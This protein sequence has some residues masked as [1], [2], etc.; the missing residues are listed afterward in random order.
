MELWPRLLY[1]RPCYS[2]GAC[3]ESTPPM[4]LKIALIGMP[5]IGKT[6]L[7]RKLASSYALGFVDLDQVIE[8]AI[9]C[10]IS[11]YFERM[12]EAAF[13]DVEAR[14]LAEQLARPEP[15][16]LSTGGGI[17]LRPENRAQLRQH[18]H[19]IYLTARLETLLRR[20]RN[21]RTRPLLQVADPLAKL[22]ELH[23]ARHALYLDTADFQVQ[24]DAGTRAT[25]QAIVQALA[26]RGV[27]TPPPRTA[28]AAPT[29]ARA[30]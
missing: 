13:R 15:F 24:V 23:A 27:P 26:Q 11:E 10:R 29:T 21:D 2:C 9:G 30:D 7:G 25:L 1:S 12:G 3:R 16:V 28:P 17:V 14:L 19:V 6:T 22:R 4:Q 8:S 20:V 18:C 5:A